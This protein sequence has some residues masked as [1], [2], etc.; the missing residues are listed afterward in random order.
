[1]HR[2]LAVIEK[3]GGT[4]SAHSP[5]PG[6]VATGATREE[7]GER[8]REAIAFHL[9]GL[10]EDGLPLP[11]PQVLPRVRRGVSDIYGISRGGFAIGRHPLALSPPGDRAGR[12]VPRP[13]RGGAGGIPSRPGGVVVC[14]D[15]LYRHRV[16]SRRPAEA[17]SLY[18][19]PI[20]P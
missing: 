5:D 4:W 3:A 13:A 18:S 2:Y 17:S 16:R 12:D 8:M 19:V 1:M 9:D 14:R 15:G 6:C 10:R 7:A 11:D 20:H